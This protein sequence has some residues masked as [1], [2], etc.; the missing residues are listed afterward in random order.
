MMFKLLKQVRTLHLKFPD[1]NLFLRHAATLAVMR[2]I[3][4]DDWAYLARLINYRI[5]HRE[6]Q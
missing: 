4:V 5:N 6:T 2:E 3:T 1:V